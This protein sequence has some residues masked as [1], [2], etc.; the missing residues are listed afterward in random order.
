M[1][2]QTGAESFCKIDGDIWMSTADAG[3]TKI[4]I[5]GEGYIT[6]EGIDATGTIAGKYLTAS[7]TI[8]NGNKTGYLD[9]KT[10]C[11][12]NPD[13]YLHLQRSN[14]NP[15]VGFIY[16][17]GTALNGSIAMTSTTNMQFGGASTFTFNNQIV[18]SIRKG[19]YWT[20]DKHYSGDTGTSFKIVNGTNTSANTQSAEVYLSG[21]GDATSVYLRSYPVYAR[22]Y[23]T[24]A[25]NVHV[26]GTGILGRAGSS[27]I[28]YKHD[29]AYYTNADKRTI[30]DDKFLGVFEKS[31]ALSLLEIPIISFKYNEGYITGE[32][33][34]NYEKPIVGF[35]AEDVASICPDC[36]TYL[37]DDNGNENAESWNERQM[38]PRMLY[39]DQYQEKKIRKLEEELRDVKAELLMLKIENQVMQQNI[40]MLTA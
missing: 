13:G 29:V 31:D 40:D 5:T 3:S 20:T 1:T 38:I 23:S 6:C 22:T 26:T 36:A 28:R 7:S 25:A 9:G 30:P 27:S 32:A 37:T 2:C 17:T 18:A 16:G 33:D 4:L 14:G 10:G 8:M 11:Y 21:G 34:F 35:V 12:I 24:S 39:I 19:G 15:Y